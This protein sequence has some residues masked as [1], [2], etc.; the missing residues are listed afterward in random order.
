MAFKL[1]NTSGI[2]EKLQ[3][4]F[5]NPEAAAK[6]GLQLAEAQGVA[7]EELASQAQA[8]SPAQTMAPVAATPP[9]E[10]KR[11]GLMEYLRKSREDTAAEYDAKTQ[12]LNQEAAESEGLNQFYRGL[13]GMAAAGQRLAGSQEGARAIEANATKVG[14]DIP[15]RREQLKEWLAN[16]RAT[17][18]QDT[19]LAMRGIDHEE[20]MALTDKRLQEFMRHNRVGETNAQAATTQKG[21]YTNALV[22]MN[23][24]KV[25]QGDKALT[26]REKEMQARIEAKR[27]AA[28][29]NVGKPSKS[30]LR[31]TE[32]L[33]E[34]TLAVP[35]E[36][37]RWVATRPIADTIYKEINGKIAMNN[38]FQGNGNRVLGYMAKMAGNLDE[39]V[40][41]E[42]RAKVDAALASMVAS[43]NVAL[44]QGALAKSEEDRMKLAVGDVGGGEW[45]VDL[46]RGFFSNNPTDHTRAM[47]RLKETLQYADTLAKDAALTQE[48]KFERNGDKPAASSGAAPEKS[49]AKVPVIIN[50]EKYEIPSESLQKYKDKYPSLKVVKP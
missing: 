39:N 17:E 6:L 23:K 21:E 4:I 45:K 19:S 5:A 3:A 40:L 1:A 18:G 15:Q 9:Q 34:Q 47:A 46:L 42:T 25:A 26:M 50:G 13:A 38:G 2:E 32:K 37:G 24:A 33:A 41:S 48:M 31:K 30:E 22:D 44:G 20:N 8:E 10:D 49:T 43:H 36:G 28:A 16:K 11:Q 35:H 14:T 29:A 12:G 7:P 27:Q